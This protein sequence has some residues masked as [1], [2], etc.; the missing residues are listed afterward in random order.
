MS[1]AASGHRLNARTRTNDPIP[2]SHSAARHISIHHQPVMG[3]PL[4]MGDG[5]ADARKIRPYEFTWNQC[6][7]QEGTWINMP[8]LTE[9]VAFPGNN[10]LRLHQKLDHVRMA[11]K[12]A[13]KW[14]M[15]RLHL[16]PRSLDA[17]H[18]TGDGGVLAESQFKFTEEGFSGTRTQGEQTQEVDGHV[19]STQFAGATMGLPLA[20]LGLAG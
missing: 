12:A 3:A 6:A 9:S 17:R 19:N 10:T 18:T 1:L 16:P 15:K 4:T 8:R 20:T 5:K 11:A 2:V 7:V 14:N 13:C